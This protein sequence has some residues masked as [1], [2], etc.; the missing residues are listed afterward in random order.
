MNEEEQ[1]RLMEYYEKH[2]AIYQ[3]KKE[4]D[5]IAKGLYTYHYLDDFKE[6]YLYNHEKKKYVKKVAIDLSDDEYE[7]V[8]RYSMHSK[9]ENEN[10]LSVFLGV[11]GFLAV[12]IA[13]ATDGDV[14][15]GV[16]ALALLIG[17]NYVALLNILKLLKS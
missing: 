15:T 10:K 8:K 3:Q 7:T 11:L 6:G 1:Q 14:S 16:V 13:V 2:N 9:T 17:M 12:I 5:L 4:A